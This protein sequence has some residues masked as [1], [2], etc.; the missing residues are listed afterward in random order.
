MK[1]IKLERGQ[2]L[3]EFAISLVIILWLLAGAVEF[4]IALFQYIQLRDAAQE[5]AL[6][7]SIHPDDIGGIEARVK[8]ASSSPIDLAADPDV[9]VIIDPPGGGC[10]ADGIKVRVEYPHKIFMPFATLFTGGT[11]T[12]NLGAEVTDTILQSDC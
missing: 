7:G 6:Y 9:I 11:K 8:N 1:K 10:V 4:G 5:G 2:S 3:V 12:I